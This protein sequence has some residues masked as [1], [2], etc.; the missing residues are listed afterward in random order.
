MTTE[1]TGFAS[2]MQSMQEAAQGIKVVKAYNIEGQMTDS[3]SRAIRSL[4]SAS[5][6]L[7]IVTA[8]SSPLMETLGGLAIAL[9][10]FYG[11]WRVIDAGQAPGTFFSFIT[12]VLL[13]YEPAKRL[14]K[15]HIELNS[16]LVGVTMLF[17]FLDQQEVE[18]DASGAQ[19]LQV[20]QGQI[21]LRD[22]TFS[23]RDEESVLNGLSFVAEGGKT[24]ALVGQS[25]GGKSTVM[26]MLLR[27]YEPT[28][29]SIEIDGQ[30]IRQVTRES[31]RRSIAYVSQET[32]LFHGTIRD[33]IAIGKPDATEAEIIA[34]A[35]AAHA[36]D[37]IMGFEKGYETN[38]GE[39]G[40]QLSGGQRQ[41]ISI[42]RAFLKNAPIL[43]LDEATSALDNE[44]ERAV[45]AALAALQTGRTTIVIA[46]RLSTIRSADKI[47]VV[48]DGRV[49][50][51]GAHDRLQQQR[52]YYA[53]LL[54]KK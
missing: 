23:Y 38:C 48:V 12:A 10:V 44:S 51:E 4:E 22:L 24:T 27:F 5:N 3:Q 47:C 1:F 43:L 16:A 26:A 49:V 42:A 14:A 29:G 19:A 2:L 40:L 18:D 52:G 53:S 50:E 39:Q 33:N 36:H 25:G 32:F 31:L 9:V 13:A 21:T 11:G 37:F 28:G 17:E 30:D 41:R 20:R 46:H 45:Q 54:E 15:L 7:A 34:A 6:K 35:K 8:R